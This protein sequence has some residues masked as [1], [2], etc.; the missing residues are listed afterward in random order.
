MKLDEYKKMIEAQRKESL[1]NAISA[2]TKANKVLTTTF[3]LEEK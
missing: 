2:L 3:D 1:Q